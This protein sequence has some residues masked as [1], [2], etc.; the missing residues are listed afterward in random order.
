MPLGSGDHHEMGFTVHGK[1]PERYAR[2][3]RSSERS[4]PMAT[5]PLP[6]AWRG[7]GKWSRPSRIPGVPIRSF[8]PIRRLGNSK[9]GKQQRLKS[10]AHFHGNQITE[11]LFAYCRECA[12]FW[13]AQCQP[14]SNANIIQY[15][16][17]PFDLRVLQA[18]LKTAFGFPKT[19]R[20]LQ[21]CLD[22]FPILFALFGERF[23]EQ[24]LVFL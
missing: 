9:R 6:S 5:R 24:A 19:I 16:Q 8:E 2:R 3:K 4:P 18:E 22:L 10:T 7:S 11:V 12:R 14:A 17:Q 15:L 23:F 21:H 13:L 1:I 20:L